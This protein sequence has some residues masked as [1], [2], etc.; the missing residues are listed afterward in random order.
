MLIVPPLDCV[1]CST[2]KVAPVRSQPGK[3][4]EIAELKRSEVK[5]EKLMHD[6]ARENKRLTEPLS[7]VR[8]VGM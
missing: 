1:P 3:Q 8:P 5:N 2:L 4:E 6:V 7:K